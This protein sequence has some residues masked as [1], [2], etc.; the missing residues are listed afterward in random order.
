[1]FFKQI[2]ECAKGSSVSSTITQL[3]MEYIED[4]VITSINSDTHYFFNLLIVLDDDCF[5]ITSET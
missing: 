3:V 4:K 5:C 1:M 2:N